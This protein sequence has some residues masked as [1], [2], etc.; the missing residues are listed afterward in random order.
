M[1]MQMSSRLNAEEAGLTGEQ[2]DLTVIHLVRS[3]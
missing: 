1:R 2:P 3:L